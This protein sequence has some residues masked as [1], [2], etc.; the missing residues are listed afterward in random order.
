MT[1]PI[2]GPIDPS[3]KIDQTQAPKPFTKEE[4]ATSE[5][6]KINTVQHPLAQWFIDQW[7]WDKD[8]ALAAEKQFLKNVMSQCQHILN[9][10]K[11]IYKKLNPDN[12]DS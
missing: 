1:N 7:G 11:N 5:T 12:M 8:K 3:A 2:G 10:Y 9:K 6:K 4:G